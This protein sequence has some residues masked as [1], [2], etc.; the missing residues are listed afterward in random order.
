[1]PLSTK[2]RIQGDDDVVLMERISDENEKDNNSQDLSIPS[3]SLENDTSVSIQINSRPSQQSAVTAS[4]ES[5]VAP[6]PNMNDV[7]SSTTQ[8]WQRLRRRRIALQAHYQRMQWQHRIQTTTVGVVVQ[9]RQQEV[10]WTRQ[11]TY[12][13][14][15]LPNDQSRLSLL[16][17]IAAD[18]HQS[19][20]PTTTAP[21]QQPSWRWVQAAHRLSGISV[22]F[23]PQQQHS[24]DVVQDN[25]LVVRLDVHLQGAYVASHY[26]WLD[27]VLV[28]TNTQEEEVKRPY[29]KKKKKYNDNRSDTATRHSSAHR[30]TEATTS[31]EPPP[32]GYDYNLRLMQHTLPPS[33]SD[34][35]PLASSLWFLEGDT[36]AFS[37]ENDSVKSLDAMPMDHLA[38]RL[39]HRLRTLQA[40]CTVHHQNQRLR[41]ATRTGSAPT[42]SSL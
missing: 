30:T 4:F 42:A 1:M 41:D 16:D 27:I 39:R 33:L 2:P 25:T 20:S 18:K 7:E 19:K 6:S 11:R 35:V 22:V 8:E 15:N 17:P 38:R 26:L 23:D 29:K 24:H 9:S 36:T 40:A 37:G 10:A 31:L 13:Q 21:S 5:D 32:P 12:V 3:S 14:C 28:Q 34:L